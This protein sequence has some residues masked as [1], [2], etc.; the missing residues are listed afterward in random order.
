MSINA[1]RRTMLQQKAARDI[2]KSI[3]NG[4]DVKKRLEDLQKVRIDSILKQDRYMD[5][6]RSEMGDK[7]NSNN[8][9]RSQKSNF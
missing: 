6:N 9:S 2:G 7:R 8:N 1:S 4:S 3:E 5:E